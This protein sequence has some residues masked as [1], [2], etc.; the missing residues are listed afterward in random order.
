MLVAGSGHRPVKQWCELYLKK[1]LHEPLRLS[2][3]VFF[4]FCFCRA[5]DNKQGHLTW[6][7]VIG[8]LNLSSKGISAFIRPTSIFLALGFRNSELRESVSL[9]RFM[10]YF[11]C[12]VWSESV[13]S[14]IPRRQRSMIIAE[15]LRRHGRPG[16]ESW[17]WPFVSVDF[18]GYLVC[19]VTP[20][21][22]S[23]L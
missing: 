9:K 19:P 13:A 7:V 10:K 5:Y 18:S 15:S 8:P 12:K 2:G 1:L 11:T 17:S 4:V 22:D 21:S 14:R 3:E 20:T 6:I 23:F 16:G